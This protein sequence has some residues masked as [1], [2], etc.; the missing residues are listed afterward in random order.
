MRKYDQQQKEQIIKRL[1]FDNPWW[2]TGK[3]AEDYDSMPRRP[4]YETL[5]S[6]VSF[7]C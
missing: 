5:S 1:V 4:Y 7:N 3:I 6:E 2:A